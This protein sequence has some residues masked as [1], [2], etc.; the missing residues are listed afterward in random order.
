MQGFGARFKKVSRLNAGCGLAQKKR[1][2]MGIF[3]AIKNT[4]QRTVFHGKLLLEQSPK[5]CKSNTLA[6][7][8]LAATLT[9]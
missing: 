3:G 5:G 2:D 4:Q 9:I 6:T 7:T 8:R 1:V